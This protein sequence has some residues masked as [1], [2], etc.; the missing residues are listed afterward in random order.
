[1]SIRLCL[2]VEGQTEEAFVKR[3]L[4]P[5]LATLDVWAT[6]RLI[7]TSRRGTRGGMTRYENAR[8]DLTSWMKED[9]NADVRFTTM[10][11]L[12][13][14]PADFPGIGTDAGQRDSY[15]RVADV[16]Q[17]L[18]A[19]IGDPRFVPYIQLHE[20]EALILAQPRSLLLMYPKR[21]LEI[22]ALEE[23]T[24]SVQS[25]ELI[26]LNDPPAKRITQEIPEYNKPV[27]GS[28]VAE[29]IGVEH[30]RRRCPHF[31]EW[32]STLESLPTRPLGAA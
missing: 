22:G 26:D 28:V 31:D 12:Y 11:D 9:N 19:D 7:L 3:V 6:A 17:A 8:F 5:H 23:L 27:A 20:F 32:L 10:F 21:E 16:E 4:A 14:L 1:M 2:V 13:G 18:R 15:V 30:I 24:K 29:H 25:P